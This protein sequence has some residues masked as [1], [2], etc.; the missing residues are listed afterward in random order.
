MKSRQP[1]TTQCKTERG[2][3]SR[4]PRVGGLPGR[5]AWRRLPIAPRLPPERGSPGGQRDALPKPLKGM[6]GGP[7]PRPH[8]S[9]FLTTH[10]KAASACLHYVACKR[11]QTPDARTRASLA[12]LTGLALLPARMPS[13]QTQPVST[14]QRPRAAAGLA[15][16]QVNHAWRAATDGV[17]FRTVGAIKPE[18]PA[19]ARSV[20]RTL[21]MRRHGIE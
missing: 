7:S 8:V 2:A 17:S 18:P 16:G 6:C 10:S 5:A 12:P 4:P 9:G 3:P 19:S 20:E 11:Y 1:Y 21:R 14:R 13:M 15:Q